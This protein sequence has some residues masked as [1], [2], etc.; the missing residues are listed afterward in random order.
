MVT[1][2]NTSLVTAREVPKADRVGIGELG[3]PNSVWL[4]AGVSENTSVE[5]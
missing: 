3:V 4:I 1:L 2:V 5:M